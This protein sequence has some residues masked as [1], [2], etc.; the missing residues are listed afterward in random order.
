MSR[1]TVADA[2]LADGRRV[3]LGV[4]DGAIV[5]VEPAG[6]A[7]GDG[8]RIELGG[9][10]VGPALVEGHIHLDKTLLGS[11]WQPHRPGAS[12]SERIAIE[13]ELLREVE[14]PLL[15][16]ATGLVRQ[17]AAFGTG[18]VRS[19]VD[20]DPEI[21]L[22]GLHAL[23]EIRERCADLIELQIVAF[24]QSGVLASP[25]TGDLLDAALSEGA[26][27]IGGLDPATIDGD[28]EG[29][30]D[31]VFGL[32][33]RY[34]KG[35]DIHL[36]DPGAL[37]TFELRCIADRAE[38]LGMQGNVV[39]SHAYSLGM[40]AAEDLGATAEARARGGVAIM[41]NAP[42]AVAMPPV[43][44]LRAAGV[45]VFAG[46]DN[47]R[48]AWWPYGNG[49]MME[50][51]MMI[52]YRQGLFTDEDLSVAYE[53]ATSEAAAVLHVPSYALE[54]GAPANLVAYDATAVAEAV[55][56]HRPRRLVVH[57]G[58]VIARDGQLS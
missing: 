4:A 46:S 29:Q 15:E 24:P 6:Q 40:V 22:A 30:L 12:V 50:R 31:V 18:Y 43:K 23:L 14:V 44:A 13:R 35:V 36:H 28:V 34:G 39:V 55:V 9:A 5:S 11:D 54:P 10:L 56:T 19:H 25:G 52:G 58:R 8:E 57:G 3:D 48:D 49:D 17:I 7:R 47:I 38:K 41:T 21:G 37:G 53:L 20:I 1:L 16:R 42:G 32:A 33:E 45:Q 27:L 2:S 26:D 51:A